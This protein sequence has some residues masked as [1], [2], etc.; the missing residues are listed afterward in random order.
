MRTM[1][2]GS[3]R[4]FRAR[5]MFAGDTREA[6]SLS[7]LARAKAGVVRSAATAASSAP[8]SGWSAH[9][10]VERL[11]VV[12]EALAVGAMPALDGRRR[13][14]RRLVGMAVVAGIRRAEL[15]RQIGPRDAEAV[16]VPAI[17]HHVGARRHVA[18]RAGERRIG[19]LVVVMRR[20]RVLVGRVALQADAVARKPQ[21]GAV[22]LVAV[23]AGDAGREHLALLERAV[24]VDLVAASAR[25]HGRAR[26]VSG[27]TRCVSD[28]HRPGTQSS[29][30]C[31]RRAWHSPQVSTSLR[32]VG[33]VKAWVALPV[34]GIDRPDDDR[35]ARRSEPAGPWLGRRSCRTAT[36]FAARAPRRRAASP[37]RG[38]PRSRR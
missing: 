34:L 27:E 24:V 2:S 17:D 33:G 18:G 15:C 36:S 13:P 20:G 28:S 30:S 4:P 7:A 35:A 10:G 11:G 12:L 26:G 6:S 8:A 3:A 32:S 9:A 14:F 16:I 38:R 5:S 1:G 25:R 31:S 22:R 37:G 23:A 19:A 29:E 21:L